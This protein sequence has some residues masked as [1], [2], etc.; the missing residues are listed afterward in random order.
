MATAVHGPKPVIFRRVPWGAAGCRRWC[1]RRRKFG[2][3]ENALRSPYGRGGHEARPARRRCDGRLCRRRRRPT[4]RYRRR[5]VRVYRVPTRRSDR[6]ALPT[7]PRGRRHTRFAN[8]RPASVVAPLRVTKIFSLPCFFG[9]FTPPPPAGPLRTT[10]E[11]D[12]PKTPK[13]REAVE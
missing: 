5:Y 7:C 9:F 2:T 11:T 3:R 4:V 6:R 10:G 1:A 8:V 13:L 12:G